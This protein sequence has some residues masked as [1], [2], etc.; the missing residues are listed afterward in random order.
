MTTRRTL[1]LAVAY[2]LLLAV[3]AFGVPLAISLRD[4]VDAE[5]R[6]QARSQ[7]DLLAASLPEL[8]DRSERRSL[9]RIVETSAESVRGRVVVTNRGGALI[10]DSTGD[11]DIDSDFSTRPEVTRALAGGAYQ[12]SRRSDTL[13]AELLATA[14][15]ILRGGRVI[16]AVRITQSVDAVNDAVRRSVLGIVLL[17]AAVLGLGVA[18]GALIARRIARPIGRLAGAAD[19]VAA[20]DLEARA[21]IEGTSEQRSLARSF[22]EMTGRVGRMI[23]SQREFVADASHEL[24]TPLT[25]LRLQIEEIEHLARSGD[26]REAAAAALH[27]VDR[28]AVIVEELLVLSRAGEHE[29]PGERVALARAA[30]RAAERWQRRAERRGIS[31]VRTSGATSDAEVAPTDLDRAL[32]SL[33]ENAILYS[34][35]DAEVEIADGPGAIVISDRGP[36]LEAGEEALVLERFYRGRAGR[37][38]PE[39]SGLGLPIAAELAG[40]WGGSVTLSNR[41]GGGAQARLTLPLA[42][43]RNSAGGRS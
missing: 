11:D 13:N 41:A 26:E 22:N 2:V 12:E 7:A 27:E 37:S 8:L 4:R 40:Q 28:L 14:V 19:E 39:G 32:D 1:I 42:G 30:D 6:G 23:E 17:G 20:G 33:I 18:A 31:L 21:R 25:G 35:A 43:P 36:G 3:V 10:A 16:G 34:P 9:E 29:L 38:G 24:R 15:P 5:V